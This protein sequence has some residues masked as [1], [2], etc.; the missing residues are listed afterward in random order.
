MSP[1]ISQEINTRTTLVTV[2]IGFHG[3]GVNVMFRAAD[4]EELTVSFIEQWDRYLRLR[5]LNRDN[6]PLATRKLILSAA[7][8]AGPLT[9]SHKRGRATCSR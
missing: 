3:L 9:I 2:D 8:R 1:A 4:Q 5:I 7:P 6:P